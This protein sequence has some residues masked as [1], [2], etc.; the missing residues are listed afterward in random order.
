MKWRHSQTQI[1]SYISDWNK[2]PFFRPKV[3]RSY[4]LKSF[5]KTNWAVNLLSFTLNELLLKL[6]TVEIRRLHRLS[7]TLVN[8]YAQVWHRRPV[9]QMA[10]VIHMLHDGVSFLVIP[11]ISFVILY[12]FTCTPVCFTYV[13]FLPNSIWNFISHTVLVVYFHLAS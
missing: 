7:V 10:R 5:F 2:S 9:Q 12:P 13:T 6:L 8:S 3:R 11:Q 4:F 1:N